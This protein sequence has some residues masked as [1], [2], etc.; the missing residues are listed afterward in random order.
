MK[1]VFADDTVYGYATR[2]PVVGGAERQQWLLARA[3]AGSGWSVTVGVRAA[4]DAGER[5]SVDGVSFVG[6]GRGNIYSSWYR[7]L[8]SERPDWWYWR[9]ASHLWGPAVEIAKRARVRTVFAAAFDTDVQPVRALVRRPRWWPLYAWGLARTDRIFVQ[10]TGQLRALPSRWRSKAHLIPSL[11]GSLP[12]AFTPHTERDKYVAWVA[13]LRQPKRP[14]VLVELARITPTVRYVVCGG[15]TSFASPEG[16]SERVIA[17][18]RTLPNV[19]FLGQ[20][21]PAEADH[22]IA[23]AAMLLS[24]SD[25]EGFPNTFLQAWAHGTPVVSLKVDPDDIISRHHVGTVPGTLDRAAAHITTLIA[26]P[27]E[28]DEIAV[29]SRRYITSAHSEAVVTTA[30]MQAVA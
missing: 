2:G 22:V 21:A 6:I 17:A 26:S 24:T 9:C 27:Q 18:L 23:N 5:C 30:F 4:L 19:D 7:F 3:L 12:T 13:M 20:V 11:A 28:R 8:V 15:S 29:R 1:I 10:H 16:Y 14:D 25:G